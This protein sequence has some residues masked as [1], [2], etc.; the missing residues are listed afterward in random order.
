[1]AAVLAVH[2]N[3]RRFT[4]HSPLWGG[5][6]GRQGERR[7]TQIGRAVDGISQKMLSRTLYPVVPSK[8]E[9]RLAEIGLRR[10]GA[11]CGVWL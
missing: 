7:F 5:L 9:I 6:L 11:F 3:F 2:R 8:V 1:M 4:V 10:G